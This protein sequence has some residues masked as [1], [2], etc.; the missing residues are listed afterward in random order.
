MNSG[1][2]LNIAAALFILVLMFLNSEYRSRQRLYKNRLNFYQDSSEAAAN[3]L[4]RQ[5]LRNNNP[6]RPV[7]VFRFGN[8]S[9]SGLRRELTY[10]NSLRSINDS[11][12]ILFSSNHEDLL[13]PGGPGA[14]F[15]DQCIPDSLIRTLQNDG[16]PRAFL[17]NAEGF[18][19]CSWPLD[20]EQRAETLTHLPAALRLLQGRERQ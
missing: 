19:L 1:R 16:V 13:K 14:D 20:A 8:T 10:M 9:F 2:F 17:L 3:Y 6:H 18:C 15:Y 4:G 5:I 7:L 11:C 12:R